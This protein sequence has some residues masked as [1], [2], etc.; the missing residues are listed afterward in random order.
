MITPRRH[1]WRQEDHHGLLKI[2]IRKRRHSEDDIL[3]RAA[4]LAS[5]EVALVNIVQRQGADTIIAPEEPHMLE[6]RAESVRPN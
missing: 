5:N 6:Q 2:K 3:A 1:L 4:F